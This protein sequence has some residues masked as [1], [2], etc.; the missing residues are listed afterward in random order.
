MIF[1]FCID[2]YRIFRICYLKFYIYI[3]FYIIYDEYIKDLYM[4]MYII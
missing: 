3:K 4:F 2:K 1:F